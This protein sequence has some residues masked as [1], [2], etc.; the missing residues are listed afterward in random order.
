LQSNKTKGANSLPYFPWLDFLMLYGLFFILV[1]VFYYLPY[2]IRLITTFTLLFLFAISQ[3]D[4]WWIALFFL[5]YTG[6]WGLFTEGTREATT[7]IPLLSF[8]PGL[9]FTFKQLFLIVA[10]AKAIYFK[11]KVELIFKKQFIVLFIFFGLLILLALIYGSPIGIILDD[12]KS[13]VFWGFIFAYPALVRSRTHTYNFIHLILPTVILV[14]FDAVFFLS[15]GGQYIGEIIHTNI[16]NLSLGF[17]VEIDYELNKRFG[18]PGWHAV[19]L[20]FIISLP[21]AQIDKKHSFFYYAIASMAFLIVIISATR[22]WF[23]IFLLVLGYTLYRI[24]R[25]KTVLLLGT[26]FTM[27]YFLFLPQFETS[28]IMFGGAFSRILTVFDITEEGSLSSQSIEY[29]VEGRLP[30][31]LEYIAQNPL[32]GWGFT[33]KRG[34]MDVGVFGQLVEMG[35]IGFSIFVWLWYSFLSVTRGL[36]KNRNLPYAYRNLFAILWI[37][38]IGLLVSHFTTNQIFGITYYLV[39]I[40]MLFWLTD[41]FT[42][43]AKALMLYENI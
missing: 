7:G 42:R 4:Y 27:F 24:K 39:I 19:L 18:I 11:R 17:E 29:K 8:G 26:F 40:T 21:L 33:E 32:T 22:S 6:P 41:F 20:G 25:F 5:I 15:T 10:L 36:S 1:F 23:V 35:L 28:N 34:D 37:G 12:L 30:Q 2:P 16:S 38:M 31:Q 3:R 43:E 13:A 14:F 9:S